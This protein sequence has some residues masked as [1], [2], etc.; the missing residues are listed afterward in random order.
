ML[1][2]TLEQNMSNILHFGL[3]KKMQDVIVGFTEPLF[4]LFVTMLMKENCTC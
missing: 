3:L 4:I 1:N 2:A